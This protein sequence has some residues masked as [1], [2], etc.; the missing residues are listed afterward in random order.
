LACAVGYFS[1]CH[2]PVEVF[3]DGWIIPCVTLFR[4][5]GT[6][7]VQREHVA[8]ETGVDGTLG[9]PPMDPDAIRDILSTGRKRAARALPILDGMPCGWMGLKYAGGGPVPIVGCRNHVLNKAIQKAEGNVYGG[10]LHHGPDKNVLNNL[11]GVNLHAVCSQCHNRWHAVNNVFYEGDRPNAGA[12]WLPSAPYWPHDPV[13]RLTDED[14]AVSEAWWSLDV[15]DRGEYP[16]YPTTDPL[17]PLG[18]GQ[19]KLPHKNPFTERDDH[20]VEVLPIPGR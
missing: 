20:D 6:V 3:E 11:P 8:R 16:L 5:V 13:T 10:H 19:S 17:L 14:I 4:S 15:A 9:R 1:E 18:S 7:T 2:N 12:V